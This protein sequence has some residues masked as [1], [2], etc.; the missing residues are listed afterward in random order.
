MKITKKGQIPRAAIYLLFNDMSV[1][2]TERTKT[3]IIPLTS[4]SEAMRARTQLESN[5]KWGYFRIHKGPPN[6]QHSLRDY[7]LGFEISREEMLEKHMRAIARLIAVRGVDYEDEEHCMHL[8]SNDLDEIQN[9]IHAYV[10]EEVG[11]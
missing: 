5:H 3:H 2:S 10:I 9:L 6:L 4:K 8:H 7:Y 11:L 1:G